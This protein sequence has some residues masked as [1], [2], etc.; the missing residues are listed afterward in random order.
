MKRRCNVCCGADSSCGPACPL[1]PFCS[2][3][4]CPLFTHTHA[5]SCTEICPFIPSS[6]LLYSSLVPSA[7]D[8]PQ[9]ALSSVPITPCVFFLF[10]SH[11]HTRIHT[12]TLQLSKAMRQLG[13]WIVYYKVAGIERPKYGSICISVYKFHLC[14]SSFWSLLGNVNGMVN[15]RFIFPFGPVNSKANRIRNL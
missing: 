15:K 5:D 11:T 6:S 13:W 9:L 14:V 7:H 4:P 3:T 1:K 10:A 2:T 8:R 12:H